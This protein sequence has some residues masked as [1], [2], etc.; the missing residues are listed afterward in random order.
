MGES[1]EEISRKSGEEL[2]EEEGELREIEE[3][4]DDSED[5]ACGRR[6]VSGEVDLINLLDDV[7]GDA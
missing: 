6:G 3:G 7:V 1:A 2:Q 4:W 5:V